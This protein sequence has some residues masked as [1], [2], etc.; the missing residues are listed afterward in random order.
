[1]TQH[2]KITDPNIHEPKGASTASANQVLVANG[3]GTTEFNSGAMA[4]AGFDTTSPLK[5][6]DIPTYDSAT[7]LWV[8]S[9]HVAWNYR[10]DSTY[11]SSS[12]LSLT[13]GNRTKIIN[14]GGTTSIGDPSGVAIYNTTTGKI[15][16]ESENDTYLVRFQ[17]KASTNATSPYFDLEFDIGGSLGVIDSRSISLNK[18]SST[19]NN[20]SITTLVFV[21]STF[22][23]NGAETYITT[24]SSISFWDFTILVHKLFGGTT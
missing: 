4:G 13:S 10:A 19:T 5:A 6:Y 16:P 24:N 2:S 15:M 8:P 17:C 12:K 22:I 21:G 20:V 9:R 3:D 18:G 1:M 14:N 7:G 11:T 23:T